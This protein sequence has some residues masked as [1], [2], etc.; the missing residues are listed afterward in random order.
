MHYHIDNINPFTK[1]NKQI[2]HK[3]IISE[4]PPTLAT[5]SVGT[6]FQRA[7]WETYSNHTIPHAKALSRKTPST[8]S[9][10]TIRSCNSLKQKDTILPFSL[11]YHHDLRQTRK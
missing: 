8:H 5:L 10:H 2:L 9:N 7:L 11:Q 1:K 6:E 4:V 3:L